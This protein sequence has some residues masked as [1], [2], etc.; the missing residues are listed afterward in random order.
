MDKKNRFTQTMLADAIKTNITHALKEDLGDTDLTS[1][2]LKD[3]I[4]GQV[5]IITKE[6]GI[7]CGVAW[8]EECFRQIDKDIRIKWLV[9]DGENIKKN[10]L[11]CIVEGLI[12][13]ILSGERVALNFLQLLSGTATSTAHFKRLI[14]STTAKVFDTRKTIPGLRIAQKYAVLIGGGNNQRIGLF[15]QILLKENHKNTY[16]SFKDLLKNIGH[17]ENIQIEVESI[18]EL[19][20]A[21]SFGVKNIL[22]DNFSV[23]DCKESVKVNNGKALLEAS[24]NINEKNILDYAK[25]GVD[26]I[27][28][29]AITKNIKAIDFSMLFSPQKPL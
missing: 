16:N 6:K 20:K 23:E 4:K 10:Q 19:E 9:E 28:I 17:I 8:V 12:T 22:L 27:S 7:L 29:G 18:K 24:G 14:K 13:S 15:D 5:R 1:N 25:T 2:L 21:L 26:R 3:D 11:I